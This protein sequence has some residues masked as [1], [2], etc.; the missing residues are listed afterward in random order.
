MGSS[1]INILFKNPGPRKSIMSYC[2]G[3]N[4]SYCHDAP[5]EQCEESFE[6]RVHSFDERYLLCKLE[7]G[8]C[9]STESECNL[10]F[11]LPCERE[12][13]ESCQYDVSQDMICNKY[14][15]YVEY[16]GYFRGWGCANYALEDCGLN[17]ADMCTAFQCPPNLVEDCTL[18]DSEDDC[19]YSHAIRV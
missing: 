13:V 6:I 12:S 11:G 9:K 15:Q 17:S 18:I 8:V 4:V 2:P 5:L 14:I 10:E 1:L 3:F 7:D 16:H 19:R